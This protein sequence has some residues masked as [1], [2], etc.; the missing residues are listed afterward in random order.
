M[1]YLFITLTDNIG[2]TFG[3]KYGY[4][5]NHIITTYMSIVYEFNV[6]MYV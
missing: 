6:H 5:E 1:P 4:R 3:G 2:Y